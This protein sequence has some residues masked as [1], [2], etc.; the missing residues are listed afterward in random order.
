MRVE[1]NRPDRDG[2]RGDGCLR[3]PEAHGVHL[4]QGLGFGALGM[5]L[6]VEC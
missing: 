4:V 3:V 5:L 2:E 6:V 1:G